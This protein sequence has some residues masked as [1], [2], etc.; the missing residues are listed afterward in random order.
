MAA[1]LRLK[2]SS[3]RHTPWTCN[4]LFRSPMHPRITSKIRGWMRAQKLQNSTDG[5]DQGFVNFVLSL[6]YHFCLNL[7]AA[8]TQPGSHLLVEPCSSNIKLRHIFLILPEILLVRGCMVWLNDSSSWTRHWQDPDQEVDPNP[9]WNRNSASLD[10]ELESESQN[11]HK[12]WSRA[13][14]VTP[15]VFNTWMSRSGFWTWKLY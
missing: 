7:P 15:L 11:G 2:M 9:K 4:S 14:I 12:S 3:P 10:L 6:A 13:G 5:Q 8:F 1:A